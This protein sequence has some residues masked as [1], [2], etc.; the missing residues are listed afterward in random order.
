MR[1]V[2]VS[3]LS[4]SGKSIALQ[5]LEDLGYYCVDNLPLQLLG[6]FAQTLLERDAQTARPTAVG[7]DV[8]NFLDQLGDFPDQLDTL[9]R[10]GFAVEVLFLQATDDALIR[11]Y[12]ETRR[13]HPLGL[14]GTTLVEAIRRERQLL[15]A[16]SAQATVVVDSSQ[17]NVH[18]LRDL[19][20]ARLELPPG[21]LTL[22]FESFGYK[23]GVPTDADFVF[24][25]RCLPNP[26]WD[27]KL[28]LLTGLDK[29]VREFLAAQPLA[30]ALLTSIR[31]FLE[32]WL[33]HFETGNRG[34]VTVA[35]GCTG[36]PA[37][38]S[39]SAQL[40]VRGDADRG[41]LT[42]AEAGC[43][44]CHRIPGVA[45]ADAYVGPPL[46]A[47]SRRSFI[48]GTLVNR[49]D[50]MARWLRDP[51]AIR[52]GSGMPDL[53]LDDRQIADIVEYLYT[54]D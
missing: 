13:K 23:N 38:R 7:I 27:R 10:L 25:A 53:D 20:R 31:E 9:R 36:A 45:G 48:A 1:M 6:P 33:P 44:S 40:E 18:E 5:T 24:D 52:P 21:V 30:D 11:R 8:R 50:E 28:R 16:I 41:Q 42:I 49:P 17:T 32:T 26:H 43:G 54:L 22:L 15:E 37:D 2:I 34:Y 29:P 12:H 3:G 46:D 35:V 47:W 51:Q 19:V 39:D 4:G 14:D